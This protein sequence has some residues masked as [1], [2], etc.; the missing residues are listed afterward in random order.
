MSFFTSRDLFLAIWFVKRIFNATPSFLFSLM[1]LEF[2]FKF[3][4]IIYLGMFLLSNTNATER[5]FVLSPKN[6]YMIISPKDKIWKKCKM[7]HKYM[8]RIHESPYFDGYCKISYLRPTFI[9]T[10]VGW[11]Y[12][13]ISPKALSNL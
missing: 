5:H 11:W 2:F 13:M 10:Y 8:K 12:P 6:M 7:S 3:P 1:R 9:S 4:V